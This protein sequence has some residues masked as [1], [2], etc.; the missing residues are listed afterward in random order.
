IKQHP[1][2]RGVLS[3]YFLN[4]LHLKKGEAVFLGPNE[5]HAYLEGTIVECMASSDN[6]V[7]AGLTS[8]FIDQQTLVDMLTYNDGCPEIMRGETATPGDRSYKVPVPEFQ[9]EFYTHDEGFVQ[10]YEADGMVSLM[11][12]LEGEVGIEAAGKKVSAGRG[13]AWLWPAALET[14]RFTFQKPGTTIVRAQPNLSR[15]HT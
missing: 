5:P 11:L 2:D 12:V 4:L 1:A 6:V 3:A 8:K 10:E 14:C 7:R 9:V 15:S 13:S